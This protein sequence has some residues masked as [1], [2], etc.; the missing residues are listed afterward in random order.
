MAHALCLGVVD[1]LRELYR[2]FQ[3]LLEL[4]SLKRYL[5]DEAVFKVLVM[6]KS[7]TFVSK[8]WSEEASRGWDRLDGI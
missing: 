5:L 7:R 3:L 4:T 8:E 6:P 1:F 2:F